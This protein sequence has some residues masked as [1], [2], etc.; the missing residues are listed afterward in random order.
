M[1]IY[2]VERT[3]IYLTA[4]ETSALDAA[5][6]RTGHTRSHL[7]RE[8]IGAVY[9]GEVEDEERVRALEQTAGV[10]GDRSETGAEVVERLRSGRLAR[11]V[12]TPGKCR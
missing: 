8:A 7:I 10:W 11:V 6:R 2:I 9:L 3:Q 1:Y 4:R 12:R 5:A